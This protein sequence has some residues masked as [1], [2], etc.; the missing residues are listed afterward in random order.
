MNN[1]KYFIDI[2][3][4]IFKIL[5]ILKKPPEITAANWY[6]SK[7]HDCQLIYWRKTNISYPLITHVRVC[8]MGQEMFVFR[9]TEEGVKLN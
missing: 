8:N 2:S 1:K 9:N 4:V 7:H 3:D 6:Y 5:K